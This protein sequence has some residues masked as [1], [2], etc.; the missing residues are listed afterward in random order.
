[1]PRATILIVEDSADIALPLA[2]AFRF[3][4]FEVFHA[5]DAVQ[6]LQLASERRPDIILMDIQL[7]DLDG[8]S[9]ARTLKSDPNTERI[10]IIAMTAYEIVGEQAKDITRYCMAYAQKPVRPRELINL[11]SAILKLSAPP[12]KSPRGPS[13]PNPP[14]KPSR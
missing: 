5:P 1:M 9:V 7:P 10:P 3:A 13:P 14:A 11:A 4:E 12:A 8:L 6:A 2:D